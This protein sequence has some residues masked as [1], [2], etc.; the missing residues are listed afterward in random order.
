MQINWLVSIWLELWFI[1]VKENLSMNFF[2]NLLELVSEWFLSFL[3]VFFPFLCRY[4]QLMEALQ[5]NLAERHQL[6]RLAGNYVIF[7]FALQNTTNR[8]FLTNVIPRSRLLK[9]FLIFLNSAEIPASNFVVKL[10]FA[11]ITAYT[12]N[13]AFLFN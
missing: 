8:F 4:F 3:E 10:N 7:I 6:Q 11:L 1:W 5:D 13:K 12:R 9:A 2:V